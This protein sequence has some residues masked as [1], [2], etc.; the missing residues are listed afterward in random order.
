MNPV[1]RRPHLDWIRHIAALSVFLGH[2]R[3][4]GTPDP[5][6]WAHFVS[7]QAVNIFFVISGSL[8]LSSAVRLSSLD[9]VVHRFMRIFPALAVVLGTTAFALSPATA[10]VTHGNWSLQEAVAY[11][12][13]NAL[14]MPG[15]KT[16]IAGSLRGTGS[17]TSWNSPLWTLFFEVSCYVGI[18][19][20]AKVM[21]R[22]IDL[23]LVVA[24][25][26]MSLV[27]S[28]THGAG[29]SFIHTSSRLGL[30]FVTGG[31]VGRISSRYGWV[32]LALC[33][34]LPLAWGE[35]FP[36]IVAVIAV[37]TLVMPVK[38]GI[39]MPR[40]PFD[41]SYGMYIWHWPLLQFVS[42]LSTG[43]GAGPVWGRQTVISGFLL[44]LVSAVSWRYVE[45][46]SL[47]VARVF[48]R[49]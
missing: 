8:I 19:L 3:N 32:V 2:A 7:D 36:L 10:A 15:W 18:L 16:E 27:Y 44:L 45:K 4:L 48:S 14:L 37:S 29:P 30:A 21:R 43:S 35:F 20:V 17:A 22:R 38:A 46:P 24:I 13:K 6:R 9:Y 34:S 1:E 12:V 33:V 47:Q 39:N 5:T 11:V 42:S 28:L 31:C 40:L 25:L 49:R 26:T 41:I 23:S